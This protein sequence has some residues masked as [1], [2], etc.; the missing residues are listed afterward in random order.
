M[1]GQNIEKSPGDLKTLAVTQ[2]P[3]ENH[4]RSDNDN[5]FTGTMPVCL[6]IKTSITRW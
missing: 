3:V 5:N 2:T 6:Y 4:Q 1:N